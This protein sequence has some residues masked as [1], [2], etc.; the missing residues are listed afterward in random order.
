MGITNL[1]DNKPEKIDCPNL[2]IT[3]TDERDAGG[4][5]GGI[6][7]DSRGREDER[8]FE[9][10]RPRFCVFENPVDGYDSARMKLIAA[11]WLRTRKS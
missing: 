2:L 10:S 5:G 6:E 8:K 3:P 7:K 11:S 4:W 1:L 9:K